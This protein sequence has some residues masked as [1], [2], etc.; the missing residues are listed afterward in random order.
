MHSTS[1]DNLHER[2]NVNILDETRQGN[3]LIFN[4]SCQWQLTH[5]VRWCIRQWTDNRKDGRTEGRTDAHYVPS[6]P[7]TAR[8]VGMTPKTWP[9]R[10]D[11]FRCLR[12]CVLFV[13]ISNFTL[14]C[15][16]FH[17]DRPR[18]IADD[19]H[20]FS[21]SRHHSTSVLPWFGIWDPEQDQ[22]QGIVWW[23]L[24]GI[25][26]TVTH[27]SVTGSLSDAEQ[28]TNRKGNGPRLRIEIA[29]G[30]IRTE[31]NDKETI[32]NGKSSKAKQHFAKLN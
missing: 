31:S 8:S 4:L 25:I 13:V 21:K 24:H 1:D 2:G 32:W 19:P 26:N 15:V 16:K 5:G 23:Q 7:A 10:T 28:P 12:K 14:C 6:G 3:W 27:P 17:T 11:T 18:T 22:H 9:L 30:R 20:N 29:A